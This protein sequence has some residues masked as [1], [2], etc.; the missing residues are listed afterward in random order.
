MG[1]YT[2]EKVAGY[3][4]Y[5][6]SKCLTEG[7]IHVHANKNTASRG[8]AAKIWVCSDGSTSVA[9]YGRIPRKD[10]EVIQNWISINIDMIISEW[11]S[12]GLGGE[13]KRV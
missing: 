7:I 6:T 1:K 2:Q 10:I 3:W 8:G 11:M 4:L 12:N 9:D 5:Y 13:L